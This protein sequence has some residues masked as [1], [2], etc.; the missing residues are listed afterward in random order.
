MTRRKSARGTTADATPDP[1]LLHELETYKVELHRQNEELR[2]SRAATEAALERYREVFEFAPVGY[3]ALEASDTIVEINRCGAQL[4]GCTQELALGKRLGAF[5]APQSMAVFRTLLAV[6]EGQ[7]GPTSGDLDLW[8]GAAGLPVRMHVTMLP[9]GRR[10]LLVTFEDSSERKQKEL[11]LARSAHAL[12]EESRRKDEFLAMLSHE[13]RNPLAPIRMSVA[14]LEMLG[15]PS[16]DARN[17]VAIIGRSTAHL[18]RI[19][20]DLLDITRITR[21]KVVLNRQTLD[22]NELVRRVLDEHA[23]SIAAR[24]L[25]VDARLA[26]EPLP[27]HGDSVRLVQVVSNLIGN[28]EKFTDGAGRIT[29]ITEI[30]QDHALIRVRDNGVGIAPEILGSLGVPFVQAPQTIDR[31]RGGLGL[32]LAM[33]RSLTELHGGTLAI[34]S[35]GLG[36]GTE[37]IVSLPLSAGV[38]AREV[39]VRVMLGATRRVLLIEDNRDAATS[40]ARALSL[41]GHIVEVAHDGREGIHRAQAFNPDIVLCDLGLPDVDGYEVA[42]QLRRDPALARTRL[43]ALTGYA[44]P[45]DAARARSAGFDTHLA[46]PANLDTLQQLLASSPPR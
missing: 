7:P 40:L 32:G 36:R 39:P 24:D 13:L 31:S 37:V 42:R 14:V 16:D 34:R 18:A 3:A 9:R 26:S 46:K 8:N 5:V 11:E 21:G 2:E 22:L 12:R 30:S 27:V 35:D 43:V 25:T 44:L 28:A 17:A 23:A 20:D 38:V 19:V 41:R 6:A 15:M 1:R 10:T 4:L 29:V 45:E 33:V